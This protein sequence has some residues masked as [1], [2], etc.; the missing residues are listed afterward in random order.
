MRSS[1]ARSS[2]TRRTVGAD[3]PTCSNVGPRAPRV[4]TGMANPK[5]LPDPTSDSSQSRPSKSSTIR[6]D[7]VRPSPVPSSRATPRP[8][9]WKDSKMRSRSSGGMPTPVSVTVT[10]SSSATARASTSTRPPS[11][12][13]LTA[14]ESRL[15]TTCLNRSSSACT[16]STS[17]CDVQAEGDAVCGGPFADERE[18]VLEGVGDPEGG[19]LEGHL[20]GFDLRQVEHLVQQLEQV[21]TGVPDVADVLVLAIVE[22]AEHPVQQHLREADDRVERGAQLVGHA[23]EELRLV[24]ARDLQL[25]RLRLELPEEPG[26][27]DRDRRLGGEGLQQ[28]DDVVGERRP[29]FGGG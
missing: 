22:L 19:R 29:G 9:C 20:A 12:V 28:L 7:R 24:P 3:S 10:T 16:E 17:S 23:G 27:D 11:G 15:S 4:R 5:V 8:P 14:L 13:N 26:V 18:G 25:G 21:P 6:R 1:E 2:S